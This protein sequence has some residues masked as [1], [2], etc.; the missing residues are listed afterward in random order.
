MSVAMRFDVQSTLELRWP[1]TDESIIQQGVSFWAFEEQQP[2]E[3]RLTDL[4]AGCCSSKA[5]NDTPC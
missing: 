4:S 1:A 3:Q 2:A 5:Q